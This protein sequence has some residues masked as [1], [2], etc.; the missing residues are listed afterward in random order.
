MG[1]QPAARVPRRALPPYS[2][3]ID[4]ELGWKSQYSLEPIIESAW[5]WHSQK[6]R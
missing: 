1:K 2:Q 4:E 6:V 5:K 3:K